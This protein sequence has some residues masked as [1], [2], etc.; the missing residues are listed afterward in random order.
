M[1]LS[2]LPVTSCRARC[3]ADNNESA[4]GMPT[5]GEV[6]EDFFNYYLSVR[7]RINVMLC[8]SKNVPSLSVFDTGFVRFATSD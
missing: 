6:S 5:S 4:S 3:G 1:S 7:Y 2:T 8:L